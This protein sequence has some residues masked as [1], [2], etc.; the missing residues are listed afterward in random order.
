M[1]FYTLSYVLCTAVAIFAAPASNTAS[2]SYDEAYD[3]A[4]TSLSSV[5]CSDG[6]HGLL[7]KG[8]STFG[9]LPAFPDVGGAFAVGGWNSAECGTCWKLTYKNKSIN[10]LAIDHADAGTFNIALAA[11]NKLTG[12]KAKS[13]GRV[14]V[15][16]KQV[17][18]SDCK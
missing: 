11:M 6:S 2:L 10:V 7:T 1:K 14:E 12:N 16:Y 3:N 4:G 15:S 9:S 18:T 17:S 8:Y 5:A 13:L